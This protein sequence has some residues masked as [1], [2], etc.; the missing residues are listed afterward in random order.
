MRVF[1]RGGSQVHVR[2]GVAARRCGFVADRVLRPPQG[3]IGSRPMFEAAIRG[4][5]YPDTVL[6]LVPFSKY[7]TT[8]SDI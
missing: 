8:C 5:E 2:R 3:R 7:A 6:Q 1:E 4:V